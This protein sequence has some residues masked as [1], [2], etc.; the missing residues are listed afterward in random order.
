MAELAPFVEHLF[1]RAGFGLTQAERDKYSGNFSD[2][3]I[4]DSLLVYDPATAADGSP[5]RC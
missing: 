1:R 2:R 5:S 4:V 3:M